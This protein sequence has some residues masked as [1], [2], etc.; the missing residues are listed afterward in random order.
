M[1]GNVTLK[2]HGT[3][4][5]T[6]T[7]W[8]HIKEK[9]RS[10]IFKEQLH[11]LNRFTTLCHQVN[12]ALSACNQGQRM[13]KQFSNLRARKLPFLAIARLCSL[14]KYCQNWTWHNSVSID[15]DNF[16]FL[17]KKLSNFWIITDT[18]VLLSN[19]ITYHG[20]TI[21]EASWI[22]NIPFC[23]NDRKTDPVFYSCQ[24]FILFLRSEV[25]LIF[26]SFTEPLTFV[27]FNL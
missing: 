20:P 9:Q 19:F 12:T 3:K 18:Y 6:E 2:T 14:V 10:Q 7:C 5:T 11:I 13:N 22:T 26:V 23:K 16:F 4:E 25:I 1:P 17:P 24:G 8:L 21:I 27:H 15:Y